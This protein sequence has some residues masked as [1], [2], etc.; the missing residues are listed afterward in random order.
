MTA[1]DFDAARDRILLGRR[2]ASNALLPDEKHAVAVHES[3]HSLVAAL[4]PHADPVAKVTILPA[5][6]AL[7]VTEQLPL[8]ERHLYGETTST[9]R[10][11]SASAA[12][13]LSW[14]YWARAP[15]APPTT[16]RRPPSWPSGWSASSGC[17]ASWGRWATRRAARC[18]WVTAARPRAV[19]PAVRR[20]HPG[21]DRSGG[22]AAA[23]GGRAARGHPHPVPSGGPGPAVR[24]AGRARDRGRRRGVPAARAARAGARPDGLEIAPGRAAAGP[25]VP[26]PAAVPDGGDGQWRRGPAPG[27]S[28]GRGA[29]ADRQRCACPAGCTARRPRRG[30]SPG[31]A[32]GGRTP[33]GEQWRAAGGPDKL[34]AMRSS[35]ALHQWWRRR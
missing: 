34:T 4:S 20:V 24:P 9:T 12:E 16:W 25:P 27:A 11:P 6:Q 28:G 35:N 14:S 21:R 19:Q 31:P 33:R 10:W 26:P 1:A 17:P 32:P 2:D 15:P 29:A 30:T 13:P 18:S 22:L 7:G 23:Q 3:G 8:A 5:G